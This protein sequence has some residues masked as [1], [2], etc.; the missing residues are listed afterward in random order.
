MLND[1][2]S[3]KNP[4]T[5]RINLLQVLAIAVEYLPAVQDALPESVKHYVPLATGILTCVL[6]HFTTVPVSF[7]APILG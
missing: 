1:D 6:R 5:S 4:F 7:R 3:A 2:S